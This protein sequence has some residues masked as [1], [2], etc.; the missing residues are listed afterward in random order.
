MRI[1]DRQ[2]PAVAKLPSPAKRGFASGV[3]WVADGFRYFRQ[4]PFVWMV[5]TV[6][7]VLT[8]ALLSL[9]PLVFLLTFPLS[10]LFAGG[11]ML[12]C[13]A[14]DRGEPLR[15]SHLFAGFQTHTG[16]LV[17]LG[18]LYL[19][20]SVLV[21]LLMAGVVAS[22]PLPAFDKVLMAAPGTLLPSQLQALMV[23]VVVVNLLAMLL[24]TPVVMAV[25]FAPALI[26]L[27][28][29]DAVTAARLSLKAC[30]V[31][32]RPFLLYGVLAM[33]LLL[34]AML[35]FGLGLLVAVPVLAASVYAGWKDVFQP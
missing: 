22:F 34:L 5:M 33:A 30:L 17:G 32:W 29:L 9:V 23:W 18:G 11:M 12:G 31:N 35:L 3:S 4:A 25:W 2:R 15:V 8:T 20:A 10:I 28:G 27:Q 19:A 24:L 14:I 13:A 6:I 26:V 16:A 1:D 21:M 7:V